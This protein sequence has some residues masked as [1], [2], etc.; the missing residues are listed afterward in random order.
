MGIKVLIIK[1]IDKDLGSNV[2]IKY[3]LIDNSNS[4]FRINV[5]IG[6]IEVSGFLLVIV[7]IRLLLN[8]I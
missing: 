8:F 3:S 7:S 6:D 1:V 5:D 4:L 2:D